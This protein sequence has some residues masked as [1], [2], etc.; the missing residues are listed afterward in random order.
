MIKKF[1]FNDS[2]M[3]ARNNIKQWPQWKLDMH[4]TIQQ[5]IEKTE[6]YVSY[7]KT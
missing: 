4:K 5:S 6:G 1:T 3:Q 7:I 2:V